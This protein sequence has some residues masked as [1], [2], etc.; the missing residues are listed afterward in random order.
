VVRVCRVPA[1]LQVALTR[2][3]LLDPAM[4]S[5]SALFS[6][7][8]FVA[9]GAYQFSALK[10][11]CVTRCQQPFPFF[12]ANWSDRPRDVFRLGVRQGFYCLGCCWALMLLMFV[13]GTANLVWMLGLA[14]LMAVEKNHA[15]GRRLAEPLGVVLLA[16]ACVLSI[17]APMTP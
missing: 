1:L 7:A 11:A 6:G 4:A 17:V 3:A 5:T 15:W 12:F 13:V 2:L 16:A 9:A 10:H 8:V 14:L